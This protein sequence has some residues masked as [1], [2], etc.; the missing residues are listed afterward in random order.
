MNKLFQ[1]I[2]ENR[3]YWVWSI[4]GKEH[5]GLNNT[6][7]TW[8]C[9]FSEEELPEGVTPAIDSPDWVAYDCDM[10]RTNFEITFKQRTTTKEK[11][12]ETRFRNSTWCEMICN[13]KPFY[14]FPTS[15][16]D[17]GLSF[18]MAKSQHLIVQMS[19]HPFNFYDPQSEHGRKIY[20]YGMPA[21]VRVWKEKE[22]WLI[23]IDPDYTE[24]PKEQWWDEYEKRSKPFIPK[25]DD[26]WDEMEKEEMEENKTDGWINWGDALS[27]QHIDWFRR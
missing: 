19:E 13:G 27:D 10:N 17:R 23:G 8:W 14:Q 18:A 4:E 6:I 25:V 20:W 7:P 9:Y 1:V 22:P 12:G 3:P 24:V 21:T 11:W 2:I 26:D 5:E 15:G 16:G